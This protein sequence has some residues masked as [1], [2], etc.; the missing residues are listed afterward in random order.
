MGS[1]L[2][3]LL[4]LSAALLAWVVGSLVNDYD[5]GMLYSALFPPNMSSLEGKTVLLCGGS[6]GIGRAMA[7][8]YAMW[9]ADVVIV[10]RT[11]SKLEEVVNT[12]KDSHLKGTIHAIA[13]D[14]GKL[15]D[16]KE[17]LDEAKRIFNNKIDIV[18]LNHIRPYFDLLED[19]ELDVLENI[20]SVNLL[21]YIRIT[22]LLFNNIIENNS[23]VI[24][25]SSAAGKVGIPF[26]AIYSATKH[27]LHGFFDSVSIEVDMFHKTS[28]ASFTTC[29][30]GTIDTESAVALTNG[31]LKERSKQTPE[32]TA[33]AI[34]TGAL[35]G[36][37][38]VYFPWHETY[39]VQ[40]LKLISP[41]ITRALV[42]NAMEAP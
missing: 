3:M 19:T 17:M 32:A 34:I 41:T 31:R 9:G 11:L 35:Q 26:T 22:K 7:L 2:W 18:V 37:K 30:I 15:E 6:R 33:H 1:L 13:T 28:S 36:L 25:V 42:K 8:E 29:V 24:A 27:A 5:K 12:A 4:G 39:P 14:L 16:T 10:S 21:S 20:V 38:E 23:T 40:W